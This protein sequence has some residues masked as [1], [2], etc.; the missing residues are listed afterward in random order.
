[1]PTIKPHQNII[2]VAM[3]HVGAAEAAYDIAIINGL[4]LTA[5]DELPGREIVIGEV[6]NKKVVRYFENLK[7]VDCT[8]IRNLNAQIF[9]QGIGYWRIGYDFKVS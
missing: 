4:E 6:V 1:M 8:T 2:D 9:N 7:T 5:E 3:Q